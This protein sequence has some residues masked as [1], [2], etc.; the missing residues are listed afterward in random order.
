MA[1]VLPHLQLDAVQGAALQ[2]QAACQRVMQGGLCLLDG[3]AL[4]QIVVTQAGLGLYAGITG[5]GGGA[6][7]KDSG[8]GAG[9]CEGERQRGIGA[10]DRA[11][12]L[13]AH[14]PL[15]CG[16]RDREGQRCAI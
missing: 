6:V 11:V 12:F 8:E 1:V 16:G 4:R 10:H 2:R 15:A 9:G 14:K 5:L 7:L 13:P 3:H